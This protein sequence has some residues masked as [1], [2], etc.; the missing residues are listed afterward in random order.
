MDK[1]FLHALAKE[2]TEEYEGKRVA[3]DREVRRISKV[4]DQFRRI[5]APQP[6]LTNPQVS[7]F[8]SSL[9]VFFQNCFV[10]FLLVFSHRFLLFL[11]VPKYICSSRF[12]YF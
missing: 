11:L 10:C 1:D 7:R 12:L 4:R 9:L 3:V 5:Y 2:F 8:V 6:Q